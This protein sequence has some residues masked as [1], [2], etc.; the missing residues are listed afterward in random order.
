MDTTHLIKEEIE[1]TRDVKAL[2]QLCMGEKE[3]KKYGK[4]ISKIVPSVIKDPSKIPEVI[5]SQKQEFENI[6]D[7][8]EDIK[9]KF[10][11]DVIVEK[12]S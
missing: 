10:K 8:I 4:D 12:A 5:L 1:E 9:E 11:C 7:S 6:K 3:L 2:M